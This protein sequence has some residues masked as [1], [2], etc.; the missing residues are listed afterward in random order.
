[1]YPADFACF[2][3]SNIPALYFVLEMFF[4][5]IIFKAIIFRDAIRDEWQGYGDLIKLKN[6]VQQET[7]SIEIT[8]H[9]NQENANA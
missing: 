7:Q 2:N 5:S 1:M 3:I 6:L 9:P 4:T 8:S